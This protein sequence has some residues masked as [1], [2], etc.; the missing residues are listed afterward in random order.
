[1]SDF[2]VQRDVQALLTA[3]LASG[4]ASATAGGAGNGV[5]VTGPSID[6]LASGSIP[7]NAEIMLAYSTTLA[8]TKT[9]AFTAVSIQDSADNVTFA[10]YQAFTD[11]GVVGTGAGTLTGVLKL[12]AALGSARRFIRLLFTPTLSNTATDTASAVA[13]LNLAGF[14]RIPQP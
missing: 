3:K 8:A 12:S 4:F 5:V 13:L 11:P 14:D 6:R 7:L 2:V 10:A 1:M 9:L